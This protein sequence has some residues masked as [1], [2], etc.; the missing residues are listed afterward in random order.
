MPV[1]ATTQ[2]LAVQV[3]EGGRK[4]SLQLKAEERALLKAT[5]IRIRSEDKR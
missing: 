1:P 4:K 2:H 5:L 3:R